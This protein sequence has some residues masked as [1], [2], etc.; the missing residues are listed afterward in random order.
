MQAKLEAKYQ[1]K[2]QCLGPGEEHSRQLKILNRVVSWHGQKGIAYEA[3]ARHVE[4][5]I[6]Q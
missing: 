2:T 3:V 5:V 1:V 6:E 4:L